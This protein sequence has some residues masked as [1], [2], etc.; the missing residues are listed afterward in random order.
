MRL[1][2]TGGEVFLA[3]RTPELALPAELRTAL[4]EW[5]AVSARVAADGP[6]ADRE[7]VSRRGRLLAGR[8]AAHAGC[9]VDYVDPV[10]GAVEPVEPA[11]S[12]AGSGPA[13]G[14]EPTPWAT[15]LPIAGFAAVAA[16]L[17]ALLLDRAFAEA[18]GLLWV[19]AY[20]LICLGV[21]PTLWL[22]RRVPVWRWVVLGVAVGLAVTWVV[23]PL[24]LLGPG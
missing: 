1:E 10:S 19:P 9:P 3:G 16:A 5:A 21:A 8:V 13:D 2:A 15:G 20:A 23:V 11:G 17:T 22:L 14:T 4:R 6:V 12:G 18:F 7:V 24:S